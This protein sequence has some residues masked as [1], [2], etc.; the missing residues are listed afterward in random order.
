MSDHFIM[1][2]AFDILSSS[3][4]LIVIIKAPNIIQN[5]ANTHK[6]KA[7]LFVQVCTN[8]ANHVGVISSIGL[9]KRVSWRHFSRFSAVELQDEYTQSAEVLEI[10]KSRKIKVI[11]NISFFIKNYKL[12]E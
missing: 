10:L 1:S 12:K 8:C 6:N 11:T 2:F 7:I 9:S 3:Q 5:T 4:A